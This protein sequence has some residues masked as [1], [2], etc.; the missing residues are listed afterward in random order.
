[1][2][3]DLRFRKLLRLERNDVVRNGL[4]VTENLARYCSSRNGFVGVVNVINVRDI[5]NV[6]DIGVA[7]IGYVHLL[8]VRTAIVIPREEWVHWP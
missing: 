7:N 6:R 8:Q 5:Q 4:T 3:R 2:R 1:M